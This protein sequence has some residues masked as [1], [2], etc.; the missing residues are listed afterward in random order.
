VTDCGSEAIEE[1]IRGQ[2][3]NTRGSAVATQ[4]HRRNAS[5]RGA[6]FARARVSIRL[7]DGNLAVS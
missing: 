2:I 5:L 3:A 4:Y 1:V 6:P 7:Q